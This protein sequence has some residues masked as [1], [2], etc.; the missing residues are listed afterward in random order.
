MPVNVLKQR[1]SWTYDPAH[2]HEARL[3]PTQEQFVSRK[4]LRRN[5]YVIIE[6]HAT[7]PR[8]GAIIDSGE[9]KPTPTQERPGS[10]LAYKYISERIRSCEWVG[11]YDSG[12]MTL[13]QA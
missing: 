9:A 13:S 5:L 12:S 6:L 1:L 11:R 8:A 3:T 10:R 2:V 4:K 7:R